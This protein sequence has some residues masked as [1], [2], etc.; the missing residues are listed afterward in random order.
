[1][2]EVCL[3]KVTV[4]G[5]EDPQARQVRTRSAL[6][7]V[8]ATWRGTSLPSPGQCP[9]VE[10]DLGIDERVWN[11][12]VVR[13]EGAIAGIEFVDGVFY[14]TGIGDYAGDRIL[15]LQLAPDCLLSLVLDTDI[16]EEGPVGPVCVRSSV[17]EL[18]P[19]NT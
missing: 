13:V 11:R 12:D 14:L 2:Q 18:W 17:L 19:T 3:V 8:V 6:G 4:V 10:L 1:V 9:D 16:G 15:Y 7:E 5:I